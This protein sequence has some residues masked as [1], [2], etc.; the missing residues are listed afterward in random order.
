MSNFT[1]KG[2][3][4]AT[5]LLTLSLGAYAQAPSNHVTNFSATRTDATHIAFTWTASVA[6]AKAPDGYLILARVLTASAIVDPSGALPADDSDFSD[7]FGSL[8]APGTAANSA[9]FTIEADKNYEFKIFPYAGTTNYKTNG[10]VPSITTPDV[11][12]DA[13]SAT[14][15][16]YNGADINYH[17][18]NLN[19]SPLTER[20]VVWGTTASVDINNTTDY[21]KIGVTAPPAITTGGYSQ[22]ITGLPADTKIY[23][24]AYAINAAGITQASPEKNFTTAIPTPANHVTSFAAATTDAT[25]IH[26]SWIASSGSPAPTGYLIK[27]RLT[28]AAA[29]TAPVNGA[30]LPADDSNFGDGKGT[31]NVTSGTAT[32]ADFTVDADESYEFKIYPYVGTGGAAPYFKTDG[33]VPTQTASTEKP[34]LT[35]DGTPV[36]S[37]TSSGATINYTL[38]SIGG[39]SVTERGIVWSTTNPVDFSDAT[40]K[41]SVTGTITAGGYT[42]A[43]TGLPAAT[44]IYYIAYA[45]NAL[46][47]T[48]TADGIF[49]NTADPVPANHVTAFTASTTDATHIHLVWTA[50]TGTPTPTGYLIKAR[51]TSAAA[52]TAPVNGVAI[53]ADDS[54]F[55]GDGK[56]TLNVTSG[57]ATTADFIVDT[58]E[59]YEFK[60]YPY[61][62]TGTGSP[63]FKTD[64]TVPTQTASTE[65]PDVTLDGTPVDPISSTGATIN[66]SINSIGGKSVT[67]RGIVWSTT[68]PVDFSDATKKVSAAG[69]ITTGG[70]TSAFSGLPSGTEIY[71][72][73]YATS[74]LGTTKTIEGSFFTYAP[75]PANAPGAGT[76]NATALSGKSIKVDFPSL[77]TLGGSNLK[78]YVIIRKQGS[79]P[80]AS[81]ITNGVKPQSLTGYVTAIVAPAQNTLNT[82]PDNGLTQKT[83]YFYA[84]VPY[85]VNGSNDEPTYSYNTTGLQTDDATTFAASSNIAYNGNGADINYTKTSAPKFPA[86]NVSDRPMT[87]NEN[88]NATTSIGRFVIND[89]GGAN[90]DGK[91]TIVTSIT[92]NIANFAS[93]VNSV[94]LFEDKP[95]GTDDVLYTNTDQYSITSGTITFTPSP[96]ITVPDG[97]SVNIVVRAWMER[98]TAIDNQRIIV[99]ITDAKTAEDGTSSSFSAANAGGATTT[100]SEN[101]INIVAGRLKLIVQGTMPAVIGAN[102]HLIAQAIPHNNYPSVDVNWTGDISLDGDNGKLTGATLT[103]VAVTGG[104]FDWPTINFTDGGT[105][106]LSVSDDDGNLNDASS[107][108]FVIGSVP[109]GITKADLP[110]C[111]GSDFTLLG[112]IKITESDT[113]GFGNNTTGTNKTFSL[114]LPDGFKFKTTITSGLSVKAAGD[115]A[116]PPGPQYSYSSEDVVQF[117]IDVNSSSKLDEIYISGLMVASISPDPI[118]PSVSGNIERL[119]GTLTVVGDGPGEHVNHGTL[120]ATEGSAQPSDLGFTVDKVNTNDVDIEDSETRFSRSTV[121][122]KLIGTP[123]GLPAGGVFTCSTPAAISKLGTAAP[124]DWRFNPS[125]LDPGKYTVTYT[126]KSGGCDYA[127][128]KEFTV[129]DSQITGLAVSYCTNS[130]ASGELSVDQTVIDDVTGTTN[131]WVFDRLQYWD[132][133]V[134]TQVDLIK[135]GGKY[136]FDPKAA[137]YQLSYFFYGGAYLYWIAKRR[138]GTPGSIGPIYTFVPVKT[139]VTPSID[140]TNLPSSFCKDDAAV[141]LIGNPANSNDIS[142]D[143]F[144]ASAGQSGAI[145]GSGGGTV[146]RIWT[147]SPTGVSGGS[148]NNSV[149]LDLTYTYKDPSTGCVA[150]SPKVTIKVAV[151]PSNVDPADI[152]SGVNSS[153]VQEVCE[154]GT[155]AAIKANPTTG[156]TYNWYSD[157]ALTTKAGLAGDNFTPQ[158][159]TAVAGETPFYMTRTIDGCESNRGSGST[160]VAQQVKLKVNATPGPPVSDINRAYCQDDAL[161]PADFQIAVSSTV[162]IN[163][164]AVGTAGTAAALLTNVD[165]PS[166]TQIKNDL[167]VNNTAPGFYKFDVTQATSGCEG[168]LNPTHVIVEVKALPQLLLSADAESTSICTSDVPVTFTATDNGFAAVAT[169]GTGTWSGVPVDQDVNAGT[170]KLIPSGAAVVPGSYQ[171]LF[172]FKNTATQCQSSKPIDVTILPTITPKLSP[173]DSCEQFRAR[174]T[175]ESKI[176]LGNHPS[177][178][179]VTIDKVQWNFGDGNNL[180]AGPKDNLVNAPRTKGTYFS[181]EHIFNN[182]GTVLLQCTMI[183]SEGCTASIQKSLQ[184]NPKPN[185]EFTWNQACMNTISATQFK[186]VTAPVLPIQEYIWNF[187]VTNTLTVANPA[188][189]STNPNPVVNYSSIGR[190]SVKLI[191]VTNTQCRDTVRHPVFIVPSYAPIKEENAYT[192][193]FNAGSNGWVA[194]GDSS[195]WAVGKPSGAYIKTDG[196]TNQ[197]WDTNPAGTS[198]AKEQSWVLSPCFNFTEA[199]KPIISFDIWSDTPFLNDGAVLQYNEDGNILNDASWKVLGTSGQGSNWYDATGISSSPGDQLS[200]DIG[201]T[202]SYDGWKHAAYKLDV[203]RGKP[204]VVFRIAFA[205]INPRRDGFA[206]DNIFIGE[207]TRTVLLEN[208]TNSSAAANTKAHNDI[209]RAFADDNAR[210]VTKVEYHTAFPGNDPINEMNTAINSSRAAFYGL[211][212]PG[213]F[214]VDGEIASNVVDMNQIYEDRVL[215]PSSFRIDITPVKVDEDVV[216]AVKVTNQTNLTIPVA[217][218]NVFMVLIEKKITNQNLLGSNG[219]PEFTYVARKMLPNAA[220]VPIGQ[221]IAPGGSVTLPGIV[222]DEL[223]LIDPSNGAIAV[224]IQNTEGDDKNVFQSAI[225]DATVVPDITTGTTLPEQTEGIRLYPN[226]V[227]GAEVTIALP[228]KAKQDLP[229]KLIDAQGRYTRSTTIPKGNAQH[230]VTTSDLTNG[231]YIVEIE[232]ETGRFVRKKIMVMH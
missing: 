139:A 33:T 184:I 147:F 58:D 157:Q 128:S 120:T 12:L 8:K 82:Y 220:G 132:Q 181:P 222:W 204:Q 66:Y 158:T 55:G 209:F 2:I 63:F 118:V 43:F 162:K 65:K 135:I 62:G 18:N 44:K 90:A 60:I 67:E 172:T 48:Q 72:I 185:V 212:S 138:D 144:D 109:V 196:T 69:T 202:G 26:L 17:V 123:D 149:S 50:S 148:L 224:F 213:T 68:T 31:L 5:F 86:A 84:V 217:K 140:L 165:S 126:V 30:A 116:V 99:S 228:E 200:N 74:A 124:Y 188:T 29:I 56:G 141:T 54:N 121:S 183:T 153:F 133:T 45:T 51:L 164:Y 102:F 98:A 94:G 215:T 231:F 100:N 131:V 85:N 192:E 36:T 129:Y 21:T 104:V 20:G 205:S 35:L 117:A 34:A 119:S 32:T 193:D 27:A 6:G 175:N 226:P 145:G 87:F 125:A 40:K 115:I 160:T 127:F 106:N 189:T 161:P 24:V 3:F 57:T 203:L 182:T 19:G 207:R 111:Y 178:Y 22:T 15:I 168:I 38:N 13:T 186:A 136:I 96:A 166:P 23:Y 16:V 191:V 130:P 151:R 88:A 167:L 171:L 108:T 225:V 177:N 227:N 112:T 155:P 93:N 195:S 198:K 1:L 92:V 113:K 46:G 107:L 41:V 169:R 230:N 159:S 187:N 14:A 216:I 199:I 76:V 61:I 221:D 211:S 64:G 180:A 114:Q 39:K 49:F 146:P 73:A 78:G 95:T 105:Y 206:F 156:T 179:P 97:G 232:T 81:A 75:A 201:W 25:H 71:Y 174:L 80:T 7:G 223:S 47:T 59:N 79:A 190:D 101:L 77:A 110:L 11:T 173:Q 219:D 218:A 70:Y 53:P 210:E 28:S 89:A 137:Q 194:G 150:T 9:T 197:A 142:A 134:G 42:S 163:W 37:I 176:Y 10:T 122:V 52:I 152:I 214:A 170:A 4:V 154:G 229:V 208:F 143:H 91:P 83:Q 103:G